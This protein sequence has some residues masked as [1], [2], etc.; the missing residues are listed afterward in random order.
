MLS[1]GSAVLLS[2]H[3]ASLASKPES[4]GFG[5]T[6]T[7]T[8]ACPLT[9]HVDVPA[10][11]EQ[12]KLLKTLSPDQIGMIKLAGES[13]RATITAAPGNGLPFGR[14]KLIAENGWFAARPSGTE[15]IYKIYVESFRSKEHLRQIQHEAESII[16][17]VFENAARPNKL[18]T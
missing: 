1:E 5:R 2:R 8:T 18:R 17:R 12:K 14:V 16:A 11:T 15:V 6:F 13:I 10:T 3:G 7:D 9:G 4:F